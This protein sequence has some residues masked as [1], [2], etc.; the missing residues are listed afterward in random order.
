MRIEPGA[1]ML[2]VSP[3]SELKWSQIL[4]V[5]HFISWLRDVVLFSADVL[6][7]CRKL[8]LDANI[9]ARAVLF[10]C[11]RDVRR[12]IQLYVHLEMCAA[13]PP[14]GRHRSFARWL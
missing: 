4:S 7:L 10:S 13:R 12:Q 9:S 8:R 11:R 14:T 1:R 2:V 6:N 5:E 3:H